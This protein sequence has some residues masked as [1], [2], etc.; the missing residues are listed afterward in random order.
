MNGL[1]HDRWVAGALSA[2]LIVSFILCVISD[3][4]FSATLKEAGVVLPV[5]TGIIAL[6]V[7]WLVGHGL[8]GAAVIAVPL[9]FLAREKSA[10][11]DGNDEAY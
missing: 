4:G 9:F 6:G 5:S 11:A 3:L 1:L 10:A 2:A 8:H 7:S